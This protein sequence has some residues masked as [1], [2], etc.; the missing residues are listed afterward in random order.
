[1]IT[2]KLIPVFILTII[3]G[4]TG[5]EKKSSV[6]SAG[7]STETPSISTD[8]KKDI[9]DEEVFIYEPRVI[10]EDQ[11]DNPIFIKRDVFIVDND[12]SSID[13]LKLLCKK[14]EDNYE[15]LTVEVN[16]NLSDNNIAI[17][18]VDMKGSQYDELSPILVENF[19]YAINKTVCQLESDDNE[20][21][22]NEIRVEFNTNIDTDGLDYHIDYS[23]DELDLRDKH[24]FIYKPIEAFED[25][26]GTGIN[27]ERDV[28]EFDEDVDPIQTLKLLCKKIE[29]N[30]ENIVVTVNESISNINLAIVKVDVT[31]CAFDDTSASNSSMYVNSI[32]DTL[33]QLED[34]EAKG[35]FDEIRIDLESNFDI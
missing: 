32:V 1:M 15:N 26:P 25:R 6:D 28:F 2:K 35:K 16:E 30:Y 7:G 22:F 34:N 4:L 17:V 24:L 8:S 13:T 5:C 29:D 14:I 3:L 27:I 20:E 21:K 10:K 19:K 31:K 18:K 9:V 11:P 12:K 23:E 33:N